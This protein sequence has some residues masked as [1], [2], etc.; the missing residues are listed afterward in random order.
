MGGG[1]ILL[2]PDL[3]LGNDHSYRTKSKQK[4]IGS[5]C[6][7]MTTPGPPDW[8]TSC[9]KASTMKNAMESVISVK[10]VQLTVSWRKR[11]GQNCLEV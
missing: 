3:T 10:A 1:A 6:P 9:L 5:I 4:N 8:H 7:A 2:S 11:E